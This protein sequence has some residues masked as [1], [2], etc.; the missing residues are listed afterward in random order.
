M[1]QEQIAR[2]FEGNDIR[3]IFCDNNKPWFCA[4]DVC[5]VLGLKDISKA[6]NNIPDKKTTPIKTNGGK[7][8]MLIINKKG[9]EKLIQCTRK[10]NSKFLTFLI[11]EFKI[12][13]SYIYVYKQAHYIDI[14]K[15]AYHDKNMKE[16]Y[17]IYEYRID[18]Y[19]IDY[20]IAIECDE[21]NHIDRDKIYEIEREKIIK[22]KLGCTFIRF[23]PDETDFNIGTVIYEINKIIFSCH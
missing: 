16:E 19:F 3:I 17:A 12:N 21:N 7:Q 14:I 20:K 4:K 2:V 15:N 9:L 18:L 23:N 11:N 8:N 6:L 22:K 13:L 5:K 10:K 1:A